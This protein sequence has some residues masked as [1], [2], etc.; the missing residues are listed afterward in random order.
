MGVK[1]GPSANLQQEQGGTAFANK[2]LRRLIG[3]K[4]EDVTS[5]W[6]EINSSGVPQCRLF[7]RYY[8]AQWRT[9]GGLG[10]SN[11]PPSG[12]SE[13]PPKLAKVMNY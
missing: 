7:T 9:E 4:T 12:N 5:G 2:A 13:G 3:Y 1:L 6:K 11:A 8:R 10:C